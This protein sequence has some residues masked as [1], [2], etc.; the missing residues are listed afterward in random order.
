QLSWKQTVVDNC[1]TFFSTA[2]V[3]AN[4]CNDN[5]HILN[6]ELVGLLGGVDALNAAADALAPVGTSD[7][8]LSYS[9]EGMLVR[10]GKDNTAR[11]DGQWGLAL[12]WQGDNTEY[13]AYFM[14]YHSRTPFLSVQNADAA[15]LAGIPG[16]MQSIYNTLGAS[17]AGGAGN[18]LSSGGYW[19]V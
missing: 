18:W 5:Y 2:D 11:D 7:V 4:G 6:S 8:G 3:A 19:G 9:Q 16:A 17:F 1:G 12:R 13:G 10:R 14:N 15:A